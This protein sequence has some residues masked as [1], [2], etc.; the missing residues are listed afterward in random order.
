[1]P[2]FGNPRAML[3]RV[4]H[5]RSAPLALFGLSVLEALVLPVP[6]EAVMAPYMQ[7][8]RDMIWRIA[9]VGLAGFL[10][11]SL[12]GYA[13]GA[14]LFEEIGQPVITAMRWQ[15]EY[16]RGDALLQEHGFWALVL[17]AATPIPTQ[18]ALLGA[19]AM[20]YPVLPFLAAMALARGARYFGL[21]LLVRLAGDRVVAFFARR[22]T[23]AREAVEQPPPP[24]P[25][26]RPPPPR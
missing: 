17:I 12:A 15:Q 21:A 6:L 9:A 3:H 20:G 16:A 5:A 7:L 8:R 4:V 23:P 1:M 25:A 22:G 19:G 14:M 13:I 26:G 18:I 2:N 11:A 24:Q 10:A